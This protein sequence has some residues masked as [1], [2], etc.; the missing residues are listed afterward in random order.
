MV[1]VDYCAV[2]MINARRVKAI[3]DTWIRYGNQSYRQ[4]QPARPV[5]VPVWQAAR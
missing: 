5:G 2:L 1:R 4:D 3:G